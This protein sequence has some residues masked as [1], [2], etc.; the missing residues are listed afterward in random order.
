MTLST[1]VFQSTLQQEIIDF[2]GEE[3]ETKGVLVKT[4]KGALTL[5]TTTSAPQFRDE[6]ESR[7]SR[8]ATITFRTIQISIINNSF[9]GFVA[10]RRYF[11]IVWWLFSD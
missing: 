2:L 9:S 11:T 8:L 4:F 6:L 3:A 1:I 7:F 10:G 5:K